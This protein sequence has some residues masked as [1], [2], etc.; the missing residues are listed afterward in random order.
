[1][2]AARETC[3]RVAFTESPETLVALARSRSPEHTS[4]SP[5]SVLAASALTSA[6][7][8]LTGLVRTPHSNSTKSFSSTLIT[9]PSDVT[10]ESIGSC[11]ASTRRE[12][13]E[14]S[15]PLESSRGM[16]QRGHK[17]NKLRLS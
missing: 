6:C 17:A 12:N 13:L 2:G 4:P 3:R 8:A 7:S 14:D 1:M 9:R 5:R 16:L 15:L 11:Q 10:Q